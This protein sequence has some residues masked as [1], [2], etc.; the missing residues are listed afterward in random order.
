LEFIPWEDMEVRSDNLLWKTATPIMHD[1]HLYTEEEVF[2]FCIDMDFYFPGHFDN[3]SIV[4]VPS[5]LKSSK[6]FDEMDRFWEKWVC[7]P[8]FS[9][10]QKAN[11]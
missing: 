7:M 3:E 2:K 5:P 4:F 6:V 1:H 11:T 9:M 10:N 8:R